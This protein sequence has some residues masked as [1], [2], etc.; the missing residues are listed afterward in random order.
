MAKIRAIDR[1]P[2][3]PASPARLC[4]L[5]TIDQ[6]AAAAKAMEIVARQIT[7]SK[8]PLAH[9]IS[10]FVYDT[11]VRRKMVLEQRIPIAI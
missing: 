11:T 3:A 2:S 5:K 8:Q 9:F 6:K 1:L 7:K 10:H 4:I